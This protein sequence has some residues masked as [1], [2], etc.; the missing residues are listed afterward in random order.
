MD[1]LAR[2]KNFKT[3]E[4]YILYLSILL[5]PSNIMITLCQRRSSTSIFQIDSW[6]LS[7]Y[8]WTGLRFQDLQRTKP[9]SISLHEGIVRTVCELSKPGNLQPQPAACIACGFTCLSLEI[10][11]GYSWFELVSNWI[12][13]AKSRTPSFS[14]DFKFLEVQGVGIFPLVAVPHLLRYLWQPFESCQV[15]SLTRY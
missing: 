15:C 14:L 11:W 9:E 1:M 13:I 3:Q 6:M 4:T 12:A 2:Q 7:F 5:F 10:G 8:V